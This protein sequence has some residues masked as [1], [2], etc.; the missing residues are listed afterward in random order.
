M[1]DEIS[2]FFF[3]AKCSIQSICIL[4]N[5]AN[6]DSYETIKQFARINAY[7]EEE[8]NRMLVIMTSQVTV[9]ADI[10]VLF[11]CMSVDFVGRKGALRNCRCLV[12]FAN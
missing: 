12:A 9:G 3:F 7:L 2:F 11:D 10:Q 8:K 4:F 6:V 1:F 5:I